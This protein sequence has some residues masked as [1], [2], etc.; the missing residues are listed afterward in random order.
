MKQFILFTVALITAI[1]LQAASLCYNPKLDLQPR[2]TVKI[3]AEFTDLVQQGQAKN[4]TV[5]K[6][7]TTV[8]ERQD[9]EDFIDE[10]PIVDVAWIK[11]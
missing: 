5:C 3:T 2:E 8:A 6:P 7:I 1:Q 11:D 9:A 4:Q 10:L